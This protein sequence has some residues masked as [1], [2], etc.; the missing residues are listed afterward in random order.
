MQYN[1]RA[2]NSGLMT[3]RRKPARSNRRCFVPYLARR[4]ASMI[5]DV[6][7]IIGCPFAAGN[8]Y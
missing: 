3:A 6:T 1:D 8:G 7:G 5:E 4:N 2:V